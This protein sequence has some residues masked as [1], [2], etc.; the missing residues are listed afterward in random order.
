[1]KRTLSLKTDQYYIENKPVKKKDITNILSS[2]GILKTNSYYIVQQGKIAQLAVEKSSG[3]FEILREI[4]GAKVFDEKKKESE[5]IL[6]ETKLKSL[7]INDYI[8]EIE[9]KIQGLEFEKS[10]LKDF[11]I[12]TKNKNY[13]EHCIYNIELNQLMIKYENVMNNLTSYEKEYK[14]VI[15][16]VEESNEKYKVEI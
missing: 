12:H 7:Q 9:H 2:V 4:A 3:R 8:T 10:E 6:N 15:N 13:I 5:N 1:M 11:N 16:Q 14:I